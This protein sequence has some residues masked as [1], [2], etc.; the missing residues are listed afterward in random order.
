[1]QQQ[2]LFTESGFPVGYWACLIPFKQSCYIFSA[3]QGIEGH[4]QFWF[5]AIP[6][7]NIRKFFWV[8]VIFIWFYGL[9]MSLSSNSEDLYVEKCFLNLLNFLSMQCAKEMMTLRLSFLVSDCYQGTTKPFFTLYP[10]L[11]RIRLVHRQKVMIVERLGRS[12]CWLLTEKYKAA[13]V[14]ILGSDAGYNI[15]MFW[16]LWCLLTHCTDKT[17]LSWLDLPPHSHLMVSSCNMCPEPNMAGKYSLRKQA[18]IVH[19]HLFVCNTQRRKIHENKLT[20]FFC[21]ISNWTCCSSLDSSGC[22]CF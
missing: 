6:L 5:T 20:V 8:Q 7:L 16:V 1:M 2:P 15:C 21:P 9:E 13:S 22:Y 4:W 14:L 10:N 18:G 3:V 19:S 17:S 12:I 11:L